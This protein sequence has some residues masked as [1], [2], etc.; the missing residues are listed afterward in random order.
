MRYNPP[1][2]WPAPPAGW[3][4][5]PG[6]EPD[7][8]WGPAPVGWPMWVED[9]KTNWFVRHKVI[10]GIGG[11]FLFLML[12]GAVSGGGEEKPTEVSTVAA[13]GQPEVDPAAADK[14]A[15]DKAAAEKAAADKAA[16]DKAAADKAAADKAAADKVAAEKA[17]AQKGPQDQ[18]AFVKLMDVAREEIRGTDNELKQKQAWK[19]RNDAM[20]TTVPGGDVTNWVGKV[21][22]VSSNGEGKGVVELEIGDKVKV[23]TWNNAF[24]DMMD[25]TLIDMDSPMYETLIELNDGDKVQFSG[26]FVSESDTCFKESSLTFHGRTQT[27]NFVFRFSDVAPVG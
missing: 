22:D 2:N 7:A 19:K 6:W 8:A 12:V 25:D 23:S 1:P 27:P 11:V 4:P 10:T 3:T 5:P 15:A 20:C 17:A 16:A 18:Q 26:T 24:S 9:G 21:K 14:A 13:E